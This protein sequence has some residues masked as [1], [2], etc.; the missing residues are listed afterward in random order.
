MFNNIRDSFASKRETVSLIVA[1]LLN[2]LYK[3]SDTFITNLGQSFNH[4]AQKECENVKE[5]EDSAE[6]T[7]G[8][9]SALWSSRKALRASSGR[10]PFFQRHSFFVRNMRSD[11][12]CAEFFTCIL[13]KLHRPRNCLISWTEVEG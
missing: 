9:F 5:S 13:K 3:N 12:T 10:G 8:L 6:S 7:I 1:L 11:A 4:K 2:N